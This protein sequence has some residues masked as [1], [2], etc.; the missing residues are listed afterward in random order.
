MRLPIEINPNPLIT[1]T[2]E[3]RFNS[4]I[5]DENILGCF[6]PIFSANFPKIKDLSNRIPVELKK[7]RPE[8]K[9][10]ANYVLQNE[11]YS[12]SIGNDVIAF[13]NL[14][15]YQLWNNY[16]PVIKENLELLKKTGLVKGIVRIGI[17]Y[18]SIFENKN[19][20]NE[21][22]NFQNSIN[23]NGY[24]QENQ[25]LRSLFIKDNVSLLVQIYNNAKL[26]KIGQAKIEGL[27]I[28]IDASSEKNLPTNINETLF[29]LIDKLHYEQKS[30]LFEGIMKK[31]FLNSLNPKY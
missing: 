27:Y 20:I 28:D 14:G 9:Y 24:N 11:K 8:L 4:E 13:E 25:S 6:Y 5:S 26:E 30:L 1:S 17:R 10:I 3:I 29:S 12:L 16:F 7:E 22:L 31:E 19:D 2:V 21:V 18:A 23:F 15:T